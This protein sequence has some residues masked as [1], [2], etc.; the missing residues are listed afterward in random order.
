MEQQPIP[1][2]ALIDLSNKLSQLIQ[3]ETTNK[4]LQKQTLQ[5]LLDRRDEGKA[6]YGSGTLSASKFTVIDLVE[7]TSESGTG[8]I[9]G[10]PGHP[11]KGYSIENTDSTN[12]FK[13]AHNITLQSQLDLDITLDGS[14]AN[15]VFLTLS[16]TDIEKINYNVNCIRSV[17][18]IAV[19]GS[20]TYKIKFVW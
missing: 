15:P 11:V 3:L 9:G 7:G 1:N 13:V 16:P 2:Y 14:K 19:A 18:L 4:D 10:S 12:S 17:H 8:N 6:I 5:E 20:P